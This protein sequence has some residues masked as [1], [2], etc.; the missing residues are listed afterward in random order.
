MTCL[1]DDPE[2]CFPLKNGVFFMRKTIFILILVAALLAVSAASGALA[3]GT[4][5]YL[6]FRDPALLK[7]AAPYLL[8]ESGAVPA[9]AAAPL[10]PNR[11]TVSST[12]IETAI[13]QAVAKVGPAVVTV[14]GTIKGQPGFFG[15]SADQQ[16]SGSGVI[17]LDQGYILTNNHVV[18]GTDSLAVVLANGEQRD[19]KLVGADR[20]ADTAVIK[21]DGSMPG[22]ASLG[23]SDNLK[24]GE[25]VIA[26]GS[27]LG[28]LKNTVT[29]GVISATG[30]SLD[31]GD[32]YQ[33]TD[34]IQTDAAINHGNSGGPLVNL[35][36][37]VIGINTLVVRGSGMSS[38]VAEGLGFAVPAN[39]TQAIAGQIIQ[40]GYFARP[41][42]GVQY[43]WITP[44]I[45]VMYDLPVKWGAYVT[46]LDASSPAQVAGLR[47][48]DIIT[49]IGDQALDDTH[50]YINALF[51]QS[52]G[53]QVTLEIVRSG[54]TIQVPVTLGESK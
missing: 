15:M 43:Q 22:V 48:G 6:T 16:V 49:K 26:I 45:A 31:T 25:T 23:N 50:P 7:A 28:D 51:A 19:A 27:P 52:P 11:I 13:T 35:A 14:V 34:L 8:P 54:K 37:E 41:Y 30:R 5:V 47:R 20:F 29:V 21:V 44:D 4:V 2:K 46:R 36:G 38:D 3:G 40:K 32:G 9:S 33:L 42:L 17:I 24:A 39:T 1:P 12:E 53:A 10:Q 18:D